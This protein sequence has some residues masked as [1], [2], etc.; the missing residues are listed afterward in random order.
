MSATSTLEETPP[1][2]RTVTRSTW[3]TVLFWHHIRVTTPQCI[4]LL[5]PVVIKKSVNNAMLDA[6]AECLYVTVK[7][8][9][10]MIAVMVQAAFIGTEQYLQTVQFIHWL[11]SVNLLSKNMMDIS[12]G[13][14]RLSARN[15]I[16]AY[17]IC[18]YD[19]QL[20]KAI[21]TCFCW[22]RCRCQP[23]CLSRRFCWHTTCL[24]DRI[25]G[26]SLPTVDHHGL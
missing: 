13:E 9:Y 25:T 2:D 14:Q 6:K 26:C 3:L 19:W 5:H 20:I 10:V 11:K 12:K 8:T 16:P 22:G 7:V 24:S 17:K 15:F 18:T 4:C 23:C 21:H 1:A